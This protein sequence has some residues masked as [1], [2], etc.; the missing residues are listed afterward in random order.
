MSGRPT[1]VRVLVVDD[2][3]DLADLAATCLERENDRFVVETAASARA[4]TARLAEGDVDC[5]VSDYDMPGR[6]GIEFLRSVRENHPDLP[7]VLFT[8]KGSE[9]VAS[10]AVSAGVTDYLQKEGGVEQYELL[11][12]RVVNAVEAARADRMLTERTRRLET[13]ISNLPGVVYRCRLAPDWPMETVEG[14]VESLTGYTAEQLERSEVVWGEDVLHPDDRESVW[15][16][17]TTALDEGPSFE[18]VYRI[19]TRDGETRWVWER[20]RRVEPETADGPVLEGFI[21][22]VTER[23]AREERLERT[24]ARLEALFENSP[25]MINVHDTEG[26]L[27]DPNP[28]LCERTGYTA[29]ELTEMK[30]WDVDQRIDPAEA[31]ETWAAMDAGDRRELSGEFRT[32]D[33]ST[34]PV[35]VHIQR[36]NLDDEDRFVVISRDVSDRAAREDE[37]RRYERIVN[38]MR[39]AACVYDERGRFETVNEYLAEFYGTTPEALA[40]EQS[41]LVPKV[42][43]AA[44]GDPYR[45]LLDGDREEVRGEVEGEFPGA[46]REVLAYR[47]TPYVVDGTVEGVVAVAREVTERR[48]SRRELE[49]TNALLS[50]LFETLPIGVLAE[51]ADRNVLALNERLLELF[52]VE[53][54]PEE[55]V[56]ADCGRLAAE[57]SDLFEDPAGFVARV[58]DLV[59]TRESAHDDGLSL[60]DGRTFS[61]TYRQ[62]ELA[63]GAGHLWVYRDTTEREAHERRLQRERDR[64]D[65]FASVVS[66]DL[67][68]PLQVATASLDLAREEHDS[69]HHDRAAA[70][71]DR[72]ARLIDDLLTLAREG[73]DVSET[74]PV[75]IDGVVRE[76]WGHVAVGDASLVVETDRTVVADR[77][78]LEQLLENL[79]RNAVEHGSAD[80]DPVTVT[81]DD[82]PDGFSVAD[83][84]PGLP[85]G[86]TEV[87]FDA[88]YTTSDDG[89]GFG[90]SIVERVAAAH[91]WSVRATESESGG[92]RFEVT[93]V[94]FAGD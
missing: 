39:E 56:G 74:E 82:L 90:L 79:V 4:G 5:V 8:G 85:D 87:V 55:Y 61:R 58:D 64:L 68:N 69:E 37:L 35:D 77:S 2:D 17:V 88:G 10:E 80:G 76:S 3:P 49:R 7:F 59:A 16:D 36:L 41:S 38:T 75:S 45:E 72:M 12:N 30:V 92:A 22:D 89:T 53:G 65:E 14:E 62:I 1:R 51:D 28:R 9:S 32:R 6:N 60:R 50:T 91:G 24:T 27:I 67:R 93:G 81:V 70:A 34:F 11:A 42:R 86:E 25:D 47:L 66:H 52:G 43:A 48:T 83:D 78:R 84:G 54:S 13:L 21:T 46:G 18:V 33:G 63:D 73:D 40:G 15:A 20:G 19:V 57:V 94:T 44:E 31:R 26:N 71:L 23:K 29:E